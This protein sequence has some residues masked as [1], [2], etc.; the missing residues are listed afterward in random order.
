MQMHGRKVVVHPCFL[1]LIKANENDLESRNF[2]LRSYSPEITYS[3]SSHQELSNGE[4]LH[5]A[6]VWKKSCR[7][8]YTRIL[9]LGS[10]IEN[11]PFERQYFSVTPNPAETA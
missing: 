10:G 8:I 11:D 4:Q 2:C 9:C 3:I 7:S 6:A 1:S 5:G